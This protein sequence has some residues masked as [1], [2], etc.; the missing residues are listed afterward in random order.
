MKAAAF[1]LL[2]VTTVFAGAMVA[3]P[4][5]ADPIHICVN[6]SALLTADVVAFVGAILALISDQHLIDVLEFL[7]T[8]A[9]D[10]AGNLISN[11]LLCGAQLPI[12][13]PTIP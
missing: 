6:I 12:P 9:L 13:L 3:T 5:A 11:A 4:A 2:L 7:P 1:G 8:W 10:Y